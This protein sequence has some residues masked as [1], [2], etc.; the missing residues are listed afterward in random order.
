[1]RAALF[2]VITQRQVVISYRRFGTSVPS[3]GFKNIIVAVSYLRFG[4]IS[5][6]EWDRYCPETSVRNYLCSLSNNPEER[7]SSPPCCCFTLHHKSWV[8]FKGLFPW[9]YIFLDRKLS[10]VT[11]GL[12]LQFRASAILFVVIDSDRIK[13][14]DVGGASATW[15][16]SQVSCRLVSCFRR[17]NGVTRAPTHFHI[18]THT[19]VHD[20][21]VTPKNAF[22]P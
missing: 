16:W 4:T 15:Y 3:S 20:R 5:V 19:F 9:S 14:H 1:M 12:S 2:R 21:M 17:W 22:L 10:D 7:C 11:V 8:V 18:H 6:R 13:K